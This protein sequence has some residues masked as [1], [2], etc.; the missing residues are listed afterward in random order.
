M[1]SVKIL[2]YFPYNARTV[3]QQS[4][5]ELLVAQGHEV[6]LFTTCAEGYLHS[7]VRRWGVQALAS[8]VAAQSGLVNYIRQAWAFWNLCRQR[9]IEVVFAHQ[10]TAALP[11]M[12]AQ[13]FLRARIAYFRHNT[14]EDY[15]AHPAKARW[16]N[17]ILN[18]AMRHLVAPSEMVR[19]FWVTEEAVAPDRITRLDYGYNF[20]QYEHPESEAVARIKAQYRSDVLLVSVARLVPAKRH[21]LMM[22]VVEAA[23][24]RGIDCQ[25]VCVG[26]GWMRAKLEH[27][28]TAKGLQ[29]RVHFVGQQTNVLDYL[30]AADLCLHLSESEASNSSVKEAAL[31]GC[32]AVVCKDVGDFCDYVVDGDNGFVVDKVAP[33]EGAVAAIQAAASNVDERR[34]KGARL[35]E[36]VLHRFDIRNVAPAYAEFLARLHGQ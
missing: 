10:H 24:E 15:L 25:L 36:T 18:R 33:V 4:V 26:D 3:E 22:Q 35:R 28:A 21:S 30:A 27:S 5:I 16:M 17:R 11:A 32:P 1:R 12:L 14:N 23:L 8:P 34:A 6:V 9:Q 20:S 7:Y 31:V 2:V 19:R 13:P 29:G